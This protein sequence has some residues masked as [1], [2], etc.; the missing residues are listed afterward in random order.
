MPE[1]NTPAPARR[2]RLR[3]M[4]FYLAL[5][6]A[7]AGLL[8]QLPRHL[9]AME[10]E[11]MSDEEIYEF[12]ELFAEIFKRIKTEYVEEVDSQQ[13]MEGAIHGMFMEL[14]PHSSWLPPE[15]QEDLM[16]DTEGEYSGVG[17]HIALRPPR[18]GGILTVIS[19]MPGS[20]AKRAGVLAWDRIIEID[21]ETTENIS[22]RD[23]VGKLTGPTGT[24]V[25]IKVWREG[26]IEPLDFTLTRATIKVDSVFSKVMDDGIGYMRIAKFQEDT[27]EMVEKTLHEFNKAHVRGVIVDLRFNAGGLL[28]GAKEICDM[29]LPKGQ[30]LVSTRGRDPESEVEYRAER[31]A[32]CEQP[33][34]VL[35]NRGSASASEIFAGAMKDTG[36]GIIIGPKDQTTYGKG[37]VQTVSTLFHSLE[38]DD[39]GNPRPSGLRLTTAKYYTPSGVSIHEKGIE[40]DI[41]VE[42][43]PG[44]ERDL[45]IHGLLGEPNQD[46]A[47]DKK[48]HAAENGEQP[49]ATPGV[50]TPEPESEQPAAVD[51][52]GEPDPKDSGHLIE[53]LEHS[54][55]EE[56]AEEQ[57]PFVDI[58]LEEAIKYLK[59]FLIFEERQ[60]A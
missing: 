53:M 23:A 11:R 6:A 54:S 39:A 46:E 51:E 49:A 37:S 40:P 27:A 52:E 10:T 45:S 9:E 38:T 4:V 41:G 60:P 34:I 50:E 31:D 5:L 33:L 25:T 35:V 59:A 19:P 43:P 21:G 44:H 26:E 32:I 56:P 36:R 13:L 2:S 47:Q 15:D 42:L 20:P 1:T 18:P 24:D 17:M 29:F 55:T 48:A 14:D 16:K 12:A 28:I 7:G 30:L 57:A 3:F 58:Q 8:S 22:L